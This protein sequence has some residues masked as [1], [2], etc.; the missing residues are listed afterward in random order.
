MYKQWAFKVKKRSLKFFKSQSEQYKL[1]T[2]NYNLPTKPSNKQDM[3]Y[4]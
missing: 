2:N 4:A 3:R 1:T